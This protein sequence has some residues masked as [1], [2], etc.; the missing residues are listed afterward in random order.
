MNLNLLTV[1]D[2][3]LKPRLFDQLTEAVRLHQPDAVACVGD[4]LDGEAP[5]Q[6]FYN[7]LRPKAAAQRLAA[8]PCEVIFTLGNHESACWDEFV[9]GWKATGRPLNV[10]HGS[11]FQFGPLTIIGFPCVMGM[12]G[13]FEFEG[14]PPLTNKHYG[15][16]LPALMWNLGPR[17]RTL[18][19]MHE[20]PCLEL[21]SPWALNEN[22]REAIERYEP[23]V[24]VCGHDHRTAE[25]REVWSAKVGDGTMCYN[26]GQQVHPFAGPLRYCLLNFEFASNEPALPIRIQ[27]TRQLVETSEDPPF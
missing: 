20:P 2:L 14:V 10:L 3:H 9:A 16:W 24:V 6:R 12:G 21:T 15:A 18:W 13:G 5:S 25:T 8:L 17:A 27:V 1:T 23:I 19:L 7:V 4:F 11:E 22:W 26:V